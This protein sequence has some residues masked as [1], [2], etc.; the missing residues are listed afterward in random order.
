M[1]RWMTIKQMR[2]IIEKATASPG[3]KQSQLAEWAKCTFRLAKAPAQNTISDLLKRAS[4]IMDDGYGDEQRR[5]PLQV[6]SIRL[7]NRLWE[8]I[9][10]LESMNVCVSR[11]LITMKARALQGQLCDAWDLSFSD[12]WLTAFEHRHGLR[13]RE[14]FGEAAS[15]DPEVVRQGQQLLQDLLDLYEPEDIYNM[16]ETGLC[17][18]MAPARSICTKKT[19]GVKKN[20]TRITLALTAN[21]AGTDV[22]PVLFLGRAEKPRCFK[23]KSGEDFGFQYKANKKAWMT[24]VVFREWLRGFDRD[25]RSEGWHVLLLL[26]NASSHSQGDLALTNIKSTSCRR[27]R[28]PSYSLWMQASY[29]HS[30]RSLDAS[31]ASGFTTRSRATNRLGRSHTQSTSCRPCA[32]ARK[33]GVKFA[34]ARPSRTVSGIPGFASTA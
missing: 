12:G 28:P 13:L 8:W 21:A 30:R 34:A 6:T 25:M 10:H 27:T 7:E 18:A 19:R 29:L 16:D 33:Y 23:R 1:A 14:R 5:K 15:A 11:E 26:D 22:L 31:N 2:A 3:M 32:G 17:Y 9:Q 24:G 4:A 20:K